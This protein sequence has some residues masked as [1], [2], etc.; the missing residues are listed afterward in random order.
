MKAKLNISFLFALVVLCEIYITSFRVNLL[1]QFCFLSLLVFSGKTKVSKSFLKTILP[2]IFIFLVGFTGTFL[3]GYN[4]VD[5]VK[6]IS[7]F[8]KPVFVLSI[9][10]LVFKTLNNQRIFLRTII[11]TAAVTA[12]IHVGGILLFSNFLSRSISDI[13]GDYGLDNFIE[14]YALFF[15]LLVPRTNIQPLFKNDFYRKLLIVIFGVSI[16]FYFSRTMF[17]MLFFLGLSFYGYAKLTPKTL[18]VLGV[19]LISV[20][21][22]YMYLET[23]KPERNSKGIEALLYKIKIAPGEVFNAK[24]NRSNHTKLWDHWRAYEAKR[25]LVL[26]SENPK[27]Y[28]FGNGHGSLVNLKFKAPLSEEGMRYI[29]VLHNGYVFVLYKT[30]FIGLLLYLTFLVGLYRRNYDRVTDSDLKFFKILVATIGAYFFF[31]SLIITGI[32]IPQ[33]SILFI[34][35]GALF[36]E[37]RA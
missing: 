3:D 15:L 33:D 27:S 2:V 19:F 25:A 21:L 6:D 9:G 37:N 29:S 28:F 12:I 32:Y 30:G 36:H 5:I 31:T 18:K 24:L 7:H 22:F 13:R 16:M 35:G 23:L 8:I 11:F 20:I 34:L 10:Y 1:I 14:I 4:K 26:M 17:G